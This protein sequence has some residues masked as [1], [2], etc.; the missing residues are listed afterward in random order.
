LTM[1]CMVRRLRRS[2]RIGSAFRQIP[3]S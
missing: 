2:L 3:R 1:F